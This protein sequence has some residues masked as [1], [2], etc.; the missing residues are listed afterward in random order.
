MRRNEARRPPERTSISDRFYAAILR[1]LPLE[2]RTEFGSEMEQAF[3]ERRRDLEKRRSM[4][5]LLHMWC[6]TIRDIIRMAPREHLSL[7]AQDTRLRFA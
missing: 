7:L 3:S 4:T 2:F 6:L 1:V 5:A